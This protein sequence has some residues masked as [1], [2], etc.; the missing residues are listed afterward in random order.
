LPGFGISSFFKIAA[1]AV[2]Y[3]LDKTFYGLSSAHISAAPV[4][5]LVA[6]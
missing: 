5:P 3:A 1:P 2:F 6:R 4:S